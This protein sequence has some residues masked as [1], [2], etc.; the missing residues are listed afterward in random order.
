MKY[1][2][3]VL[4]TILGGVLRFYELGSNPLWVDEALFG[5]W[6]QSDWVMQEFI[7]LLICKVLGF[8]TEFELRFLS[9]FFGTLT[10]PA[11]WL[12]IDKRKELAALLVAVFPIFIFWSRMARPYAVAGFFVVLGWRWFWFYIPALLT[13]SVSLAGIKIRNKWY[14]LLGIAGVALITFFIRPDSQRFTGSSDIFTML[15]YS[16]RWLYIPCLA[17]IMYVFNESSVLY[18]SLVCAFNKRKRNPRNL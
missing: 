7:P 14:V 15:G 11:M 13:T 8:N 3:I 16:S 17:V 10:I 1:V 6:V 18:N 5:M 12:V 9:A 2:P 4:I